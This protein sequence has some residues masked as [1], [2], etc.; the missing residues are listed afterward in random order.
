MV[1]EIFR[2]YH[3]LNTELLSTAQTYI[4][5]INGV[6]VAHTGFIYTPLMKNACRVHRFVVL[7]D[8]QGCGIGTKF[9][10]ACAKDISNKWPTVQLMTT[11][12]AL[13]GA[14]TRSKDWWLK[15]FGRRKVGGQSLNK[16]MRKMLSENTSRG[17]ITYSFFLKKDS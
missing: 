9:I 15:N 12:P 7:P 16:T 2:R 14:L 11:T 1:W 4:G 6:P 13:V 8:Y 17:R 3:Y 5:C 10:T